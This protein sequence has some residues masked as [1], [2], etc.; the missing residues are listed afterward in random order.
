MNYNFIF[1]TF[2]NNVFSK[3]KEFEHQESFKKSNA[4]VEV[5][6]GLAMCLLSYYINTN[7][8]ILGIQLTVEDVFGILKIENKNYDLD[9]IS[10]FMIIKLNSE[11]RVLSL[12]K[13]Q[14]PTITEMCH[15]SMNFI[16]DPIYFEYSSLIK[17]SDELDINLYAQDA[18]ILTERFSNCMSE[19][20]S[21]NLMSIICIAYNLEKN[22]SGN[23]FALDGELRSVFTKS[24]SLGITIFEYLREYYIQDKIA[25]L[26]IKF[27]TTKNSKRWI[28]LM[29]TQYG[30]E[31]NIRDNVLFSGEIKSHFRDLIISIVSNKC[32]IEKYLKYKWAYRKDYINIVNNN[33]K[34]DM[35]Y[36]QLNGTDFTY[37]NNLKVVVGDELFLNLSNIDNCFL[38]FHT[39][40]TIKKLGGFKMHQL[41][42]KVE[43]CLGL[44]CKSTTLVDLNRNKASSILV[45]NIEI[46][47]YDTNINNHSSIYQLNA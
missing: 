33:K 41:S 47:R 19:Y 30:G 28:K 11:L 2:Y 18:K 1:E 6:R 13:S 26:K 31:E 36:K 27:P 42:I 8:N 46:F 17:L 32:R 12:T 29:L 43:A 22:T 16:N 9:I 38:K 44:E 23:I 37:K 45:D 34:I 14:S 40:E 15:Y 24:R 5:N 10:N 20:L 3:D 4:N 21:N 25:N 35:L 39:I 7:D